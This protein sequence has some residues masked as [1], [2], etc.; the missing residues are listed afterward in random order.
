MS[1][2]DD[3]M[4]C[5]DLSLKVTLH[6]SNLSEGLLA[7][8]TLIGALIAVNSHVIQH[9]S[10]FTKAHSALVAMEHLPHSVRS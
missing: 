2:F 10:F 1:N 3:F 7:G 9:I 6:V 5:T 8:R 4:L